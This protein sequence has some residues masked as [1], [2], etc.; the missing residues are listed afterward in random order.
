M[1][2]RVQRERDVLDFLERLEELAESYGYEMDDLLPC[3]PIL[4]R[5]KALLWYRN[6][7]R[8]WDSWE[9]FVLDLKAFYLPPGLELELEEQ[10]RNRVQGPIESAAEYATRIQ[11]LMRRH[12][13]M[14]PSARLTRLYQNLRPEYRRYM[15]R[16]EF[17]SVPELLRLAGELEQLTVQEKASSRRENKTTS[18]KTSAPS[19]PNTPLE[20]FEYN[21]RENCWRCRQKGHRK[22]ECTN[23]WVKFWKRSEDRFKLPEPSQ[24]PPGSSQSGDI[25]SANQPINT[26]T[27][28]FKPKD[29]KPGDKRPFAKIEVGQVTIHALMDTGATASVISQKVWDFI[30]QNNL[31]EKYNSVPVRGS[32]LGQH[33][34][35]TTGTAWV[36]IREDN[37]IFALP[38]HIIPTYRNDMLLGVDNLTILGYQLLKCHPSFTCYELETKYDETTAQKEIDEL[39]QRDQDIHGPIKCAEHRIKIKPGTEPI[40]TRYFP[41][42]P[43]MQEIMNAEVDK[44]LEDGIIEPSNSPWNSPVVLRDAGT[45]HENTERG[46]ETPPRREPENKPRKSHF[47]KSSTVYLGHVIDGQGIRT[48]PEKVKAI[49][50]IAPPR[51]LKELRQFLG[52][53]SWYRRFIPNCADRT[54]P[55]T[56]LLQKRKKWKWE[57]TEQTAFEELKKCLKTAPI[58]AAPDFSKSFSVQTDASDVGIGA[59]L[60]QEQD[61]NEKVIAYASRSLNKAEKNYTVTEKECLAVVW[62]IQKMRPYL[63]GYA[64]TVITDHQSL[65]WLRTM[66]SPSGRV[67]R[68]SLFL[69]QYDFDVV[70]RKGKWNKVADALSRS[71]PSNNDETDDSRSQLVIESLELGDAW[72]ERIK[73]GVE[74]DPQRYAEYCLKDG[75]LYRHA[76]HSLDYTDRGDTWKLCIPA[77]GV[78]KIMR[79]N[80]DTPS[81]GHGGIAK[82]IARISRSYYWPRMRAEITEYVRRCIKCQAYKPSQ[83]PP[84]APMGTIPATR[85]WAVVSADIIG[86]KPRSSNGMSYLVVF[87][88]KFTKWIEVHP[89]RQQKASAIARV[90]KEHVVL[91]FGRVETIITDNGTP[92]ISKEFT[93]LLETFHIKH[94]RTPILSTM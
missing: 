83:Q 19:K 41:K 94:V 62:A 23:R 79:E 21:W 82:T 1:G 77:A 53:I 34:V 65:K 92:F 76:Y 7:K 91:R 13:Q 8:V 66:E 42:N 58:L 50:E 16:T 33:V 43:K 37:R 86:P 64:F 81:A 63:E 75:L 87:Q 35:C 24:R 30:R 44:M 39:L 17:S 68:W 52:M 22:F 56:S 2:R 90:F 11:T 25:Q 84:S 45:A 5:E 49:T 6:N 59:V 3:I 51:N 46:Y 20:L 10:I 57:V 60:T 61:G 9:D 27:G 74:N 29:V 88:D 85:P 12:G 38:F 18:A 69:Q 31:Y 78:D 15:K 80:H 72:Y 28:Q 40:K 14:S 93:S 55:L 67:A 32:T 4:L 73:R 36:K 48:D 47:L 26:T 89:L 71:H 54:K 70:Y